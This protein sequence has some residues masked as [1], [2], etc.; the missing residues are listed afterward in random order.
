VQI[1][2]ATITLTPLGSTT[3]TQNDGPVTVQVVLTNS[4]VPISAYQLNFNSSDINAGELLI[5]NW[6]PAGPFVPTAQ[7]VPDEGDLGDG[8]VSDNVFDTN[9]PID[10]EGLPIVLGT[11]EVAAAGPAG[12]FTVTV[13]AVAEQDS[14]T[15][16]TDPQSSPVAIDS[17]FDVTFTVP[18]SRPE[19]MGIEDN[20]GLAP[21]GGPVEFSTQHSQLANM[22]VTFNR[23]VVVDVND[24]QVISL[25]TG[26]PVELSQGD[27]NVSPN[28]DGAFDLTINLLNHQLDDGV[29]ELRLKPTLEDMVGTGLHA[30]QDFVYRTH[31]LRGDFDG[32]RDY[33]GSQLEQNTLQHWFLQFEGVPSFVDTNDSG[34]FNILDFGP[35][36]QNFGTAL[37][38]TNPNGFEAGQQQQTAANMPAQSASLAAATA[39]PPPTL[40]SALNS[41]QS[42]QAVLQVIGEDENETSSIE[43]AAASGFQL[44]VV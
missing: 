22:V 43:S 16:L 36:V 24:V 18:L 33:D 27:L 17:F 44:E 13:N 6:Q 38:F 31:Q 21:V 40:T 35:Y 29:I 7:V 42:G 19:V 28:G 10:P 3:I 26:S 23:Q 39:T 11:F 37:N 20:V 1:A 8:L 14:D 32:D 34:G 25:A 4:N 5:S 2:S 41:W 15:L 12:S 30:S 9:T